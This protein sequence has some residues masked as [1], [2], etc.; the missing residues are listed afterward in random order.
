MELS[1]I[2]LKLVNARN[3]GAS[4][5]LHIWVFEFQLIRQNFHLIL[6]AR[7][8][9][10]EEAR[11]NN[12][13]FMFWVDDLIRWAKLTFFLNIEKKSLVEPLRVAN[14]NIRNLI[15]L[16]KIIT[17][18]H[19]SKDF[20]NNYSKRKIYHVMFVELTLIKPLFLL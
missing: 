16:L 5:S 13:V 2:N 1:A 9:Q 6:L 4:Q 17:R 7:S 3:D 10:Y 11:K 8:S 12:Y 20:S 15:T 19:S 14:I 18:T